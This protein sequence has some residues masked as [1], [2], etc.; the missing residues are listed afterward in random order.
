MSKKSKKKN[1]NFPEREPSRPKPP[2]KVLKINPP[3][4]AW[5]GWL[6]LAA[7]I[8]LVFFLNFHTL[9]DSDIF[10]HLK[11]GE[12]IFATHHVPD[13]DVY[14]FTMAGKEWIDAQWLFQLIVFLLYRLSGYAGMIV[15]AASSTP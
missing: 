3:N 5:L 11:T 15:F 8:A 1:K 13:K 12:I 2:E 9:T 7:I 10:W 14:S 6:C 4:D